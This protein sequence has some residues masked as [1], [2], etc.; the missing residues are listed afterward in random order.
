M[1]NLSVERWRD[2]L[3]LTALGSLAEDP[4]SI[5]RM[6]TVVYN[7]PVPVPGESDALFWPLWVPAHT[8]A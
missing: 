4:D 2:G 6:H 8:S 5:S 1:A 3:V 7:Y